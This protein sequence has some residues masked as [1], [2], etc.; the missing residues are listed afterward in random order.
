MD[1]RRRNGVLAACDPCRGRKI[2]C[3][4]R[5]PICARCERR[6][7]ASRCVYQRAP[8]TGE[9]GHS[10]GTPTLPLAPRP[11][12]GLDSRQQQVERILQQLK[13][14]DRL[15]AL[16]RGYI[17]SQGPIVPSLV[18]LAILDAIRGSVPLR[19]ARDES[20]SDSAMLASAAQGTIA[21]S[22]RAV[23]ITATTT[24]SSFCTSLCGDHVRLEALGLV[25]S[26]A[27]RACKI[28]SRNGDPSDDEFIFNLYSS[29]LDCRT[30]ARSSSPINDALVWLG[31]ENVVLTTYM[32]GD[33]SERL[34]LSS[35]HAPSLTL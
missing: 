6:G 9:A 30:L 13:H 12:A 5:K 3:D 4:R 14:F 33:S 25:Y 32:H 15:D 26:V 29:S 10:K 20:A 27:A 34:T 16:I 19:G 1:L 28:A 23:D 11:P 21:A 35:T 7:Q 17:W 24:V 2:R 8:A 22:S 18:M 31:Y